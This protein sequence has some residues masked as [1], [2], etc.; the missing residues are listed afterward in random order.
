MRRRNRPFA[1]AVIL[2]ALSVTAMALVLQGTLYPVPDA[3]KNLMPYYFLVYVVAAAAW[4]TW[5]A[6]RRRA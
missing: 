4:N 2:A 5:S 6:S 1:G 3:P